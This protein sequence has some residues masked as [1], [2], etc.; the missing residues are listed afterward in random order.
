MLS[1]HKHYNIKNSVKLITKISR[2]II[3]YQNKK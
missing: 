2:F 3:K 1:K